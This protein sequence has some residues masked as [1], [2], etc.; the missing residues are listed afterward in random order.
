M[1][2]INV[3]RQVEDSEVFRSIDPEHYLVHVFCMLEAHSREEF[4]IGYYLK[5]SDK[6]TVL[7]YNN[8]RISL[9]PAQDAL[10]EDNVH[11]QPL[12]MQK[13][14]ISMDDAL[15]KANDVLKNNYPS[16]LLMKAIVL[17]Q[18]L[19]PHGQ[20]WNIT[21]ITH[22]FNVINI[23]ID[24]ASGMILHHIMESLMQWKKE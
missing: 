12:D 14:L 10:K 16:H 23:K 9:I 19:Q 21:V 5:K 13:V 2:I 7:D 22:S 11:I 8:G 4:Q 6:I 24:A 1:D 15:G 3:V 18:N 20:I 17:L